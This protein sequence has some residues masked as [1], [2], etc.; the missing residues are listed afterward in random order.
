MNVEEIAAEM[1]RL[2]ERRDA[3]AKE[4]STVNEAIRSLR[5]DQVDL[6][7]G[8]H[9]GSIVIHNGVQYLVRDIERL[10][11]TRPWVIGSPMKKDGTFGIARRNL[12]S[13]WEVV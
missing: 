3:L 11:W 5:L 10:F 4:I 8:L 9:V 12:F 2:E 1:A 6:L 7:Y 13:D